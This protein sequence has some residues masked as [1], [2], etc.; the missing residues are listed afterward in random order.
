MPNYI[1]Q[2]Y[3]EID[4]NNMSY[5][6]RMQRWVQQRFGGQTGDNQPNNNINIVDEDDLFCKIPTA[7]AVPVVQLSRPVTLKTNSLNLKY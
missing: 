5:W 7:F 4:L 3:E 1:Q 2:A 6:Q